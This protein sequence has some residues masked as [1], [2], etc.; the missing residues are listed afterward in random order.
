[1]S[2][3]SLDFAE[4]AYPRFDKLL[5][6]ANAELIYILKQQR[7]QFLYIWGERGS[8]KSHIL[9]AWVGEA[10]QAGYRAVYLD[11]NQAN[12][13]DSLIADMQF[14]AIDQVEKLRA[15]EQNI[16]FNIFNNFRNTRQGNLL[17]SSDLHPAKLNLREDLRTRVAYCLPY[18]V[19]SLSREEKISALTNMAKARQLS[20]DPKI[21]E[22]LLQHWRQDMNSLLQ[23]FNDLAAYSIT[24][25]KPITL[26]LLRKLLKQQDYLTHF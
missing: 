22:Y 26:T 25:G 19:K 17:L 9:Q 14:I 4:P 23:M 2:Q 6:T 16:L 10:L 1:M 24:V 21:Y 5:G 13:T 3:L 15:R 7:D 8:G 18:E 20:I 11:A 12:L